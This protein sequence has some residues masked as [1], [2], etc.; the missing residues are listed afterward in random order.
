MAGLALDY[1]AIVSESQTDKL[2]ELSGVPA[3]T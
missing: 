1:L 2:A 3:T